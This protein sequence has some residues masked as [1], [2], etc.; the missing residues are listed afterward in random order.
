MQI[1]SS[2]RL[3]AQRQGAGWKNCASRLETHQLITSH[4]QAST[5]QPH[6]T[7]RHTLS[8]T[9]ALLQPDTDRDILDGPL[10]DPINTSWGVRL[11]WPS[12]VSLFCTC[13]SRRL[14]S[15]FNGFNPSLPHQPGGFGGR[16]LGIDASRL[17]ALC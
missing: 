10:F 2:A 15:G 6:T 12:S 17:E 13:V 11:A 4:L 1:D 3:W 8:G 9:R 16:G 5:A 7:P 14:D